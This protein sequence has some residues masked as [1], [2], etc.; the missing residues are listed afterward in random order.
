MMRFATPALLALS[1]A[2]LVAVGGGTL[3]APH[4]FFASN[5]AVL[6][7]G[8]SLM[9]EIRA[10]GAF[11]LVSGLVASVAAMRLVIARPVLALVALIYGAFGI[12][13]LVSIVLDGMPSASLVTAAALEVLVAATALALLL[14]IRKV[15]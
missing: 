3:F 8:P 15:A 14:R 4:A 12:G 5:G 11:L 9:S 1:G 13:R 2:G 6:G 7:T 10:P